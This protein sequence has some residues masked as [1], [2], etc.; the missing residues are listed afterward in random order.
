M[1]VPPDSPPGLFASVKRLWRII[2]ATAHNR[3]ELLLVELEE[4][5]RRAV[6]VLLLVL[7]AGVAGLMTLLAGSFLLVVI[8]WEEHRVAV[9]GALTLFY[10]LATLA[11]LWRLRV[12]LNHWR[13]LPDTVEQLK[14]DKAC[15]EEKT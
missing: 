13:L 11:A 4:E 12:R 3:F 1:E 5:R 10:L 8:F 15:W 6:A 14:K 2:L 9:L 7:A